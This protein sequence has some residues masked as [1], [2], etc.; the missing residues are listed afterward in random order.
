MKREKSSKA[1]AVGSFILGSLLL[2]TFI[3]A[4]LLFFLIPE[5]PVSTGIH[6]IMLT[7]ALIVSLVGGIELIYKYIRFTNEDSESE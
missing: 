2:I 1:E 5:P 3:L 7:F 4:I 6:Y